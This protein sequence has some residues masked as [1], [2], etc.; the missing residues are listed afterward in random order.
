[1]GFF[2]QHLL[3]ILF[4]LL[5]IVIQLFSIGKKGENP[6][7][8]MSELILNLTYHPQKLV[9]SATRDVVNAWQNYLYLVKINEE[10]DRLRKEIERMNRERFELDEV[11][12]QNVRLRKLLKLAEDTP[13]PVISASVI[14]A[15]PSTL[16]SQVITM[17][18]GHEDGI[19]RGMPVISH[20][21]LVGRVHLVGGKSSQVLLI[22]DPM[23]SVDAYVQRTRARGIVR[24]TGA[25]CIM[26]YVEK[27]TGIKLGDKVISSGKDGFFPK[28]IRIGVVSAIDA[29]R[30]LVSADISPYVNFNTLGEILIISETAENLVLNE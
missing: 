8:L 27:R 13:Y 5:L 20:N 30:A 1:M 17:D 3:L 7:N 6:P 22:A 15:S 26:N 25:G 23:S 14:G 12:A 18:K 21:G 11:Q 16:R 9:S 24:G 28:G 2:K 4:I 10:N 29:Q 19:L